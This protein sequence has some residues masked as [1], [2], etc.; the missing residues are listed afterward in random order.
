MKMLSGLRALDLTSE[1]GFFCGKILA[2]LG[3]DLIKI[4]RPGGDPARN[5]GPFYHD[6]CDPEKSLYWFAYNEGKRGITLN[7]EARE[8]QDIFKK[9]LAMADF[10][11]ESFP[12]GYLDRLGL[13]YEEIS[14]VNH[15][16]IMT[17]ITP[18]GQTGPYRSYKG[19]DLTAMAM[20]GIMV[21][22]GEPDGLPCRLDPNHS[23]CLAGSAAALATMIAHY[24]RE[25]SGEG[26]WVDV[27]M[28]ECVIRENYHEVPMSW[29][30]GH[31]NVRR[32]GSLMF[33]ANVNTRC[34]WP[35]KDG[36]VTWTLWGGKVGASENKQLAKW[37]DE[38][39]LLG[40][41]KSIDW[42]RFGFDDMTQQDMDRLED[43]IL[44]LM[45]RYTKKEIEEQAVK[46]GIRLSAVNDVRDLRESS[47]LRFRKYWKDIEHPELSDVITYPGQLFLSNE[48]EVKTQ[49]RAPLIGEH[50]KEI[51]EGELGFDAITIGNLREKGII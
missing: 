39:G 51:Y 34:L 1:V 17:S 15:R 38:E 16:I 40:E 50:N 48:V 14:K 26:Q 18:F 45:L 11:L 21:Q 43:P 25:W 5:F 8:G 30:F 22:N 33:R 13:G 28:T 24:Y 20:G 3:I 46:R 12:V 37:M 2:Q 31:Y 35:C 23:Y 29:E 42:D 47:Q 41:L 4:E 32:N 19:T 6:I 10:V 36:Y 49:H 9:L 27:S 7:I 44:K